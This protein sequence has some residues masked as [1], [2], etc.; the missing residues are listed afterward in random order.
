MSNVFTL[1]ALREEVEREFA[2]IKIGLSD[3]TD[4]TLKSMVRLPKKTRDAVLDTLGSL[5]DSGDSESADDIQ[6]MLDAAT[7]ILELVADKGKQLTKEI[8]GDLALTMKVL[9]AWLAATQPGEARNSP[10]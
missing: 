1:D 6:K 8:G 4:A 3:G 7:S 9:E 5:E 2:P 10:A